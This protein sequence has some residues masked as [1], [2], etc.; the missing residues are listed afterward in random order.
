MV[1]IIGFI[2]AFIGMEVVAW[3]AHKFL[4]HSIFW[5][6][7]KDHHQPTGKKIQ[8]NDFFFLIFAIPT[9]LCIMLGFIYDVTLSIGIGFGC[10]LYGIVYF[11]LHEVL[12]HRRFNWLDNVD[13][14]YFRAV[15]RGHRMHHEKTEKEDGI[16]FGLMFV[17]KKCWKK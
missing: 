15:K 3:L 2:A 7:H 4:M 12:I 9:W 11:L 5:F 10:A 16:S 8:R 1:F 14:R 6:V 17:P 13:N